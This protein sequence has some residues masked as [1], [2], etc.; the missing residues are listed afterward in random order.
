MRRLAST[1]SIVTC[2]DESGWH[3]MAATAVTSVSVD[4]PSILVCVNGA[5][6]LNRPLKTSGRFCLN[7]LSIGHTDISRAFGGKLKGQERFSIGDWETDGSSGLPYLP[8]AQANLF[9]LTDHVVHYGTHDI[10]IGR[11]EC[12]RFAEEVSPLVYQNGRYAETRELA[13][14]AI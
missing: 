2:A 1:V 12:V 6:S 9:C 3:G 7:M 13:S 14:L 5:A 10:F 4:P 8:D 11:V